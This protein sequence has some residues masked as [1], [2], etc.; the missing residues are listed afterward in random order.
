MKIRLLPR[1]KGFLPAWPF[2][3]V[4][5]GILALIGFAARLLPTRFYPPCGFHLAFGHPCPSCG[6]TRM[7][8]ALLE[9]RPLEALRLQPFFFLVVAA[10]GLWFLAGAVA[11]LFQKELRIDLSRFDLRWGWLVLLAAVLL[12]WAY[13]WRVG[14]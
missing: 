2:V 8:F 5:L 11:R 3:G 6:L 1:E 7:G 13:L 10:L 12:N 4:T 9:G 14:V